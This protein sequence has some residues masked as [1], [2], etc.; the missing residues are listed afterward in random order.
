[1]D[2]HF[3]TT[4]ILFCWVLDFVHAGLN[5]AS[6]EATLPSLKVPA[7]FIVDTALDSS[8]NPP[9]PE[10]QTRL[11][12]CRE[13]NGWCPYSERVWLALEVK[14]IEYDTVLI[15]NM[16]GQRPSWYAG[17]TPQVRFNGDTRF[18][19][20][21]MDLVEQI[22]G[23]DSTAGMSLY[24]VDRLKEV[25][26]A[27][28]AFK[29]I[30]PRYTR[31]SSRAAFLFSQSGAPLLRS[32]FEKCLEGTEKL[33][34]E[35]YDQWG[36]PFFCGE[37][38]TAADIA[39]A[40]FLERYSAQLP[41]LHEGLYP[42]DANKYPRLTQWYK[43]METLVPAYHS[44]VQGDPASWSKVLRQQG[45]GNSGIA[46]ELVSSVPTTQRGGKER[47]LMN[48]RFVA[49]QY[50]AKDRPW[51][52][53]TPYEEAVS[54]CVK[55]RGAIVADM[56]KKT[57]HSFGNDESKAEEALYRLV[58]QLQAS[59]EDSETALSTGILPREQQVPRDSAA[60]A[61][62]AAEYMVNRICVP[63][64][65]GCATA[66]CFYDTKKKLDSICGTS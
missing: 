25:M 47:L 28:S 4:C 61:L 34:E 60:V 2:P 32:D 38:I 26:S 18:R 36:G 33:L 51:V 41:L 37:E 49:H 42:R 66:Q 48:M 15:D 35:G 1:M 24:P 53:D 65:M 44:R 5:W 6:I 16:G 20:E 62:M 7:P 40:P 64:D 63:R 14:N 27:I 17:Q 43:S 13:R 50:Y 59:L 22:D 31:P 56:L 12:L 45:F 58:E 3:L 9:K 11:V 19:G 23:L 29:S 8:Y 10:K 57:G 54:L 55:N 46:P 39:W 52:A 30:Y 21:S